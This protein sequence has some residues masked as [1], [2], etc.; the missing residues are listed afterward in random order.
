ML[1]FVVISLRFVVFLIGVMGGGLRGFC[2]GKMEFGDFWD[3]LLKLIELE[4]F[5]GFY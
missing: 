1:C 2:F 4:K 5:L 3:L